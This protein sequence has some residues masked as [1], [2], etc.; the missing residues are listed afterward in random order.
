MQVPTEHRSTA[1][2]DPL[3][4]N[5]DAGVATLDMARLRI[6]FLLVD[7]GFLAYWSLAWLHLF[8]RNYLFKD[9]DNPIL[10]AWN[11]SFL[12][13]DLVVSATG[14]GSIVCQT[15]G[16]TIWQP[17]AFM[18]LTLT[19]CSGLQAIAFWWL[20]SDFDPLWWAPNLFLIVYPLFFIAPMLREGKGRRARVPPPAVKC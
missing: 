16:Q 13:L 14:L 12:P 1:T 9:Y 7:I 18:S 20:R 15:R 19:F 4:L 8:P 3:E 2:C 6:L 11:F 17:L 10:D 5:P